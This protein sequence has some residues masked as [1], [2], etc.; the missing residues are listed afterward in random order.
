MN[1]ISFF[2]FLIFWLKLKPIL[3]LT[4][5][6]VHYFC[7]HWCKTVHVNNIKT[8]CIINLFIYRR[9]LL[10]SD[11]VLDPDELTDKEMETDP[12]E[13]LSLYQPSNISVQDYQAE[14][15]DNEK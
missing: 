1:N 12:G 3:H 6:K 7:D 9:E 4:L 15:S 2:F 13:N 14:Q 8:I 11:E 10:D 5:E